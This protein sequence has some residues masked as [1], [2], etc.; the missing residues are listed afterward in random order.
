MYPVCRKDQQTVYLMRGVDR[1]SLFMIPMM[2]ANMAAAF[3]AIQREPKV[4]TFVP[5]QPG[6]QVLMQSEKHFER[7]RRSGWVD[8]ANSTYRC[9]DRPVMQVRV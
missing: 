7:T 1:C 6:Q 5:L 3:T 4:R 8:A 9:H 2:I